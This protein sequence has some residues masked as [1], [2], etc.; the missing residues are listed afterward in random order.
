MEKAVLPK[1]FNK[2]K[3]FIIFGKYFS[4]H[5]IDFMRRNWYSIDAI[6][7]SFVNGSKE[8]ILYEIKT[9]NEYNQKLFFKPKMTLATHHLYNEAKKIGLQVKL[10]TVHF[11]TNWD[12]EVTLS[13]FTE[14]NYCVDKPKLYDKH[15]TGRAI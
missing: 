9:K 5:Q 2:T 13:E 7:I 15:I 1:F 4:P 14:S 10:A 8:I 6:E 11:Y 12:Y 3:Y